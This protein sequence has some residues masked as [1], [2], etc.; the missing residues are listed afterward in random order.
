[1]EDESRQPNVIIDNGSGYIKAGLSGEEEPK[2]FFPN[3]VGDGALIG[4]EALEEKFGKVIYPIEHGI[5]KDFDIMEKIWDRVFTKELNV[6]PSEHNV[7]L[8]EALLNQP[9]NREMMAQIMFESFYVS[10][11]YIALQPQLS[12]YAAGKFN[13]M[14]VELGED[15]SQFVPIVDCFASKLNY[16][17]LDLGGRDLSD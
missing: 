1:M 6:A 17:Y 13:G 3:C 7:L 10:G 16:N 4:E 12:I 15:I 14:V 9:K 2:V 8:T 5:I 11:L